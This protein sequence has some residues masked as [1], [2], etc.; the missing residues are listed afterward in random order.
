MH[1]I[2]HQLRKHY[3][4][5]NWKAAKRHVTEFIDCERIEEI[6]VILINV[7]IIIFIND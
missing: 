6:L 2:K 3:D 1:G 7:S 4:P 5:K